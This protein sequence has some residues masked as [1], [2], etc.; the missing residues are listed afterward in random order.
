VGESERAR[1]LMTRYDETCHP[2]RRKEDKGNVY[3][4]RR[5]HDKPSMY[6]SPQVNINVHAGAV[7]IADGAVRAGGRIVI[8]AH[9]SM[10]RAQRHPEAAK[11]APD[12]R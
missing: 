9:A 1:R 3:P 6:S 12:Q 2:G 10:D 5:K 7:T 8:C 11:E 4:G